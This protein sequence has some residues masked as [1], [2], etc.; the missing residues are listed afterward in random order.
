M[1]RKPVKLD[2]LFMNAILSYAGICLDIEKR[3]NPETKRYEPIENPGT[4]PNRGTYL[5]GWLASR[6][7]LLTDLAGIETVKKILSH[8]GKTHVTKEGI[9][10]NAGEYFFDGMF[11]VLIGN[12]YNFRPTPLEN[13]LIAGLQSNKLL[14]A[15]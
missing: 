8:A 1:L 3:Y 11:H 10:L 15:S 14:I 5:M 7:P 4:P 13:E 12:R 9:K 6:Y 2:D